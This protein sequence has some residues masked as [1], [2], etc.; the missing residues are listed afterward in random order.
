M[1]KGQGVAGLT[2]VVSI[3]ED[4]SYVTVTRRTWMPVGS[5]DRG[6]GSARL[7]IGRADLHDLAAQDAVR[8]IAAEVWKAIP[9]AADPLSAP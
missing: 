2:F 6:L 9:K 5:G 8:L 3:Y 1:A 4:H 7:P